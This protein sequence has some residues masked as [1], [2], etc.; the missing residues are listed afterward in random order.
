MPAALLNELSFMF[1]LCLI[2]PY[3]LPFKYI[4]EQNPG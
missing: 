3:K 1:F 2:L 4:F